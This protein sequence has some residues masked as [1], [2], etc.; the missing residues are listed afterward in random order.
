M[1]KILGI[2]GMVLIVASCHSMEFLSRE[3]QAAAQKLKHA[4]FITTSNGKIAEI[5]LKET[6]ETRKYREE[7]K[8]GARRQL[9]EFYAK[10]FPEIDCS[11]YIDKFS[12]IFDE[13][14][15][16]LHSYFGSNVSNIYRADV[17]NLV[18][19][20]ELR[21]ELDGILSQPLTQY[22]N[23]IT[24]HLQQYSSG[25]PQCIDFFLKHSEENLIRFSE[26]ITPELFGNLPTDYGFSREHIRI[27]T[28]D[29][30]FAE[31]QALGVLSPEIIDF[32]KSLMIKNPEADRLLLEQYTN[33][34][35]ESNF[36][37][38]ARLVAEAF[39]IPHFEF[40]RKI[41]VQQYKT[42]IMQ[43]IQSSLGSIPKRQT[44]VLF[45]ATHRY[46]SEKF[47]IAQH[48]AENKLSFMEYTSSEDE[49]GKVYGSY[50]RFSV[51]LNPKS[52]LAENAVTFTAT[53]EKPSVLGYKKIT[54]GTDA[55]LAHEFRHGYHIPMGLGGPNYSR[56]VI[57][58]LNNPFMKELLFKDFDQIHASIERSLLAKISGLSD[59]DVVQ[60]VEQVKSYFDL[61]NLETTSDSL[62]VTFDISDRQAFIGDLAKKLALIGTNLIWGD[63][64]E[65]QNIIGVQVVGETLFVNRLSDLDASIADG[66][67]V[68]WT[69]L[70][71]DRELLQKGGFFKEKESPVPDSAAGQFIKE[72]YDMY[73]I[74]S[75][76]P[77]NHPTPKALKALEI[78]HG[79]TGLVQN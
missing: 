44:F 18:N 34:L 11:S 29:S 32:Y 22:F 33:L 65:I 45:L 36:I 71:A 76:S 13:Q 6:A 17:R 79:V 38:R 59:E 12:K 14:H 28:A 56:Y 4:E 20:E 73:S 43:M 42:N 72:S 35:Q 74:L 68:R 8:S 21:N 75:D 53:E 15:L 23:D 62:K 54:L 7:V 25:K 61:S 40:E 67:T 19:T 27:I 64:E 57:D 78:L 24:L 55:I 31:L 48:D 77:L 41:D 2:C 3:G 10:H 16:L 39:N 5:I 37:G 63:S 69:H 26:E 46:I 51:K 1:K 60:F 50:P 9:V 30:I 70:G 49:L 52:L 58:Y 47:R 66:G